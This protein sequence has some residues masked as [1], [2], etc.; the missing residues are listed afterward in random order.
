MAKSR[1][2]KP[3]AATKTKKP[4]LRAAVKKVIPKKPTAKPSRKT[5]SKGSSTVAG[6]LVRGHCLLTP[7]VMPVGVGG[8]S[9]LLEASSYIPEPADEGVV[10]EASEVLSSLGFTIQ[11]ASPTSIT[12]EATPEKFHEV[13]GAPVKTEGRSTKARGLKRTFPDQ[14][15]RFVGTPRIPESLKS[16]VEA[17]VFPA[18]SSLH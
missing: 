2:T 3:A 18:A 17:C 15:S 9:Q 7:R 14:I 11:G 10:R 16:L 1:S 5:P 8:N 4:A 6:P 12:V 13:F